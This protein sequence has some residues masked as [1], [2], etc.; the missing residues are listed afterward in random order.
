M[1]TI[2]RRELKVIL[3]LRTLL[4]SF[5]P[6][7]QRLRYSC[8]KEASDLRFK[9]DMLGTKL[10]LG[11]VGRKDV[12]GRETAIRLRI[13]S[14]NVVQTIVEPVRRGLSPKSRWRYYTRWPLWDRAQR[15]ALGCRPSSTRSVRV[16]RSLG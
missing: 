13:R 2:G 11:I 4:D 3:R 6:D 16:G 7:G 1:Q 14:Y 8:T 9:D 15:P 5:L 10:R 12:E